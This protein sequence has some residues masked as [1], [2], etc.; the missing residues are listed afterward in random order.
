M[1]E[2]VLYIAM[3]LDGYIADAGRGVGW[4]RGDGS[5]PDA[6]GSYSDFYETVDTVVMGWNTYRQ[7]VTEL[8]PGDWPYKEKRSVV[9]THRRMEDL[10]C[11][12]FRNGDVREFID[13]IRRMPGKRIWVCGGANIVNGLLQPNAIDVFHIAV[14]PT[15][16][17]GGV[18][19]FDELNGR[20]DLKLTAVSAYN[21]IT[22]VVYECL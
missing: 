20:L 4:L 15:I 6:P 14:V 9:F 13:D 8:S 1:R 22:E 18:R 12:E 19:L 10:P 7:I 5:E 11:V 21:G 16:L 17:G 3:S 2:V